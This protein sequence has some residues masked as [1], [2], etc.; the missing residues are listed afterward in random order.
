GGS[1][2]H[3]SSILAQLTIENRVAYSLTKSAVE[4]LT[5]G[6]ALDLAEHNIR[7]NTVAPGLIDTKALR[8]AIGSDRENIETFIPGGHFGLPAEV[9]RV[10]VFLASD[11]A[12]Y[13][14]GA[15]IPVDRGLGIREAGPR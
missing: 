11:A 5:R 4:G 10:I 6:L 14:N 3:I 13:I 7:V 12:S 8:A 15:L 1:I 2:I 9:A